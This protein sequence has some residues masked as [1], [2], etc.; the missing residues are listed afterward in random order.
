MK[1]INTI[2]KI[3]L[4]TI[5]STILILSSNLATADVIEPTDDMIAQEILQQ[6]LDD[7]GVMQNDWD[8]L[9]SHDNKNFEESLFI[10]LKRYNL[11]L[12]SINELLEK[13]EK[14]INPLESHSFTNEQEEERV[15]FVGNAK[16]FK[17]SS[18]IPMK[19][20]VLEKIKGIDDFVE[21]IEGLTSEEFIKLVTTGY[22]NMESSWSQLYVQNSKNF[23]GST[24]QSL[25]HFELD[26]KSLQHL[27]KANNDV[28][29]LLEDRKFDREHE[30]QQILLLIKGKGFK[31]KIKSYRLHIE[32][33]IK[34]LKTSLEQEYPVR[35]RI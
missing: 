33:Q 15:L 28:L 23:E 7:F 18:L 19:D 17:E 5:F 24:F 14:I 4:R 30:D 20:Y 26:L 29:H 10:D 21:R 35:E 32:G 8:L 13:L 25:R 11:D 22:S 9:Y 6:V 31:E 12:E 16:S 34:N 2:Y 3:I 1:T 27:D